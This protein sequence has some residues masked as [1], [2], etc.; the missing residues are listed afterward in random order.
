MENLRPGWRPAPPEHANEWNER[1]HVDETQPPPPSDEERARGFVLY[2]RPCLSLVF[3]NSVPRDEDRVRCL[4]WSAA[5]GGDEPTTLAVYALRDLEKLGVE[6]GELVGRDGQGPIPAGQIEIRVARGLYKRLGGW[7]GV[8]EREFMYMPSW[9]SDQSHIDMAAGESAWFWITVHVPEDAAP[10]AYAGQLSVQIGGADT[11]ALS[12]EV[13]V[14]PIDLVEL[15]DYSIG[16]YDYM[17]HGT[18]PS[19]SVRQRYALMR[20][21]G[22]TSVC[23]VAT[24]GPRIWLDRRGR[25][26]VD[27]AG[28]GIERSLEAYKAVGFPAPP[29]ITLHGHIESSVRRLADPRSVRSAEIFLHVMKELKAECDR[30]DWPLPVMSP[31]DEAS[32]RPEVH[33][34]VAQR[35]RLMKEAGFHTE[36]N[37]FLAY[38]SPE[39]QAA[40][41]PHLDVMNLSYSTGISAQRQPAWSDCVELAHE[42]GKSLWTYNALQ[43]GSV[44]PASWRFLTG[45]FFRTWGQDCTGSFFYTLDYPTTDPYNDLKPREG[46]AYSENVRSWY[47]PDPDRGI[48]G[49]P[50]ICLACAGEGITDLRYIVTLER[51]IGDARQGRTRPGIGQA[52][53]AAE[54]TLQGI[55]QGFDFSNAPHVTRPQGGTATSEWQVRGERGADRVASGEYL[56]ANGWGAA[57]YDSARQRIAGQ[58]IALQKVA[59]SAP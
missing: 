58:I 55:K 35:L 22:M 10:G 1:F 2:S 29:T 46:G 31:R 36:L 30:R 12:I 34:Q 52:A 13:Q 37:H 57:D 50:S 59:R 39:W 23:I 18:L 21:Y 25:P 11:A 9:L 54:R 42:H 38:P 53:D 4:R 7:R 45:W 16:Y 17:D 47:R 48:P 49:G 24:D 6:T 19:W 15:G 27:F 43:P 51:L 56:Y 20:A 41:L 44:Q 8:E 26:R 33:R 32:G 28:S 40:C 5:P 14:L 3:D